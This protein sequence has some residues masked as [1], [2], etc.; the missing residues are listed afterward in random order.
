[1]SKKVAILQSNYIPW[2]GYFDIIRSVDE[3]IIF[4]Q[5]QYT[6]NDWRNR[7]LIKTPQGLQ[8]L[9]IPVYQKSLNQKIKDTQI[10]QKNWFQKHWQAIRTNYAKAPAFQQHQLWL[11][12]LYLNC[13]FQY[14]SEINLYFIQAIL[15]FL[16]IPTLVSSDSDYQLLGGKTER[17]VSLVKQAG[18]TE[19]LSGP[20]AKSYLNETLFQQ[21]NI[22]ISWMDYSHYKTYEQIYPPF[23]GRL[24]ILDLILHQGKA[25]L[26]YL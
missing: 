14:L 26:L 21:E 7:N 10:A 24:S 20:A 19:Y 16:S 11:E 17:L 5:A 1:M 2:R 22:K 13:D 8:W 4:D 9:T 12:Q 18:G 15:S 25:S 3:F 23:D 6:K